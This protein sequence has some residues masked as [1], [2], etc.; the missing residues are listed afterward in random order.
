M[1]CRCQNL[2]PYLKALS[3]KGL[4]KKK[5]ASSTF[6]FLYTSNLKRRKDEFW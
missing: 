2:V 6:Q 3:D 5:P 4:R 1:R